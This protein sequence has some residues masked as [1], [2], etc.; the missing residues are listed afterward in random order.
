[1]WYANLRKNT[2][3]GTLLV[4]RR[5]ITTTQLHQA[6]RVQRD[7]RGASLGDIL[8]E[9]GWVTHDDIRR[10]LRRQARVRHV[11][12]LL[13]MLFTPLQVVNAGGFPSTSANAEMVAFAD[14]ERYADAPQLKLHDPQ[15]RS[16]NVSTSLTKATQRAARLLAYRRWRSFR[17]DNNELSLRPASS[18]QTLRQ[19]Y[20]LRLSE[21]KALLRAKFRF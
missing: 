16:S 17:D 6:V 4:K 21:D 18:K 1:M 13:A 3:L 12:A 20:S 9:Q 11:A 8:V 5:L 10:S 15:S 2:R 19:D 14:A 7:G